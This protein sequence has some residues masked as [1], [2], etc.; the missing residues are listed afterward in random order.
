MM[1]SALD[2]GEKKSL[3]PPSSLL[4]D[5][6]PA[7]SSLFRE[8]LTA[9]L[10]RPRPSATASVSSLRALPPTKKRLMTRRWS[11]VIFSCR[12]FASS[13]LSAFTVQ[14]AEVL[15]ARQQIE[16]QGLFRP[17]QVERQHR[18]SGGQLRLVVGVLVDGIHRRAKHDL[19][20]LLD[21]V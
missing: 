2:V 6:T 14:P 13:K 15:K 8:N 4:R 19:L 12:L 21:Q 3:L 5:S 10:L 7:A 20:S 1:S 9:C 16:T 11:A 17:L 18:N